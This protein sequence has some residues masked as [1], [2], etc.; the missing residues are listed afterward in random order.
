MKLPL[1]ELVYEETG[2][3]VKQ[4]IDTNPVPGYLSS[5]LSNN[6]SVMYKE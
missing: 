6:Y 4:Q 2:K 1:P 5:S 3:R